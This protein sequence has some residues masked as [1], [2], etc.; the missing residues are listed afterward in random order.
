MNPHAMD[1]KFQADLT[2]VDLSTTLATHAL[3][4]IRSKLL[5]FYSFQVKKMLDNS[6]YVS[7]RNSKNRCSLVFPSQS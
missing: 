1:L 5:I 6:I 2:D 3:T 4:L 7:T